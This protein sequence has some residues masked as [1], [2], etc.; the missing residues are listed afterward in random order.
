M[1]STKRRCLAITCFG[2]LGTPLTPAQDAKRDVL[3]VVA[4]L[5]DGMRAGDSAIVRSVFHPQVRMLTSLMRGGKPVLTIETGA[6]AFV[7]AV[8]TPHPQV[9]DERIWNE[10]VELDGSL[11]SV[12]TN[13][14]FYLG[15][16]LSH[17]GIDHFLLARSDAGEWKI[18]ELADTRRQDCA[19]SSRS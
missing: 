5:F 7:K 8:G 13:Y 12:W 10:K 9:W 1:L 11:A 19:R 3:V 15:D 17:C 4:R 14:A 2:L 16:K 6:D 18:I